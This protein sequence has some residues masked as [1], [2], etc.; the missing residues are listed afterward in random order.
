MKTG[1]V[2]NIKIAR[3]YS[4]AL[5]SSAIEVNSADK[6]F[7]DLIFISETMKTNGQLSA[8]LDNPVITN[9]DKTDVV[10]K[11]FSVHIDKISLDFILMLLEKGR[12]SILNEVV[13]QYSCAYN[14]YKNII[15]PTVIS[16]IELNDEQKTR[17]TDK[18][19]QKFSKTIMPEYKVEPDIIG[20]LIIEIDDKTID[21]SLKSK[22][23]NMKKQLTKGNSYGNN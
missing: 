10:K 16:A 17:I 19:S 20:G 1:D 14:R 7:Q 21:C 3:K 15:K 18:L 8:F 5:I 9:T 22:F 2:K 11:L 13:N 6:V 23:E 12:L 4:N